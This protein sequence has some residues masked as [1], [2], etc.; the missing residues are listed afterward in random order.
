MPVIQ[1]F[2]EQYGDRVD[3]LGIDYRT[4]RPIAAMELA[5]DSGVTY[6]LL[7]DPQSALQGKPPFPAGMRLPLFA[8][9]DEPRAGRPRWSPVVSTHVDELVDLVNEHLGTDL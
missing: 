6:P 4:P 7:A 3:V 8:F 9:V 1:D 5:A 2:H